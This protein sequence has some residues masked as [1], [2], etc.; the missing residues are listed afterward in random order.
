M[1]LAD[2]SLKSTVPLEERLVLLWEQTGDEGLHALCDGRAPIPHADGSCAMTAAERSDWISTCLMNC[3]KNTGNR[4]VFALLFEQNR[5]A[6]LHAIQAK[7]R[8]SS[9]HVDANDVL[10]EVF[11]NIYRYPHR[12][13][14]EHADSFRNW[15]HRIVRNTLLKFLKNEVRTLRTASLDEEETQ[16]ADAR[17]SSPLRSAS[18][19]ESAALVDWAYLVYLNLYLRHFLQLSEK[20]RRALTMV[21]VEGASYK[22]AATVLGIRLENL[23]M[24]IFRGRRK[25][26]RGMQHSLDVLATPL[27]APAP[28][29]SRPLHPAASVTTRLA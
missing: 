11:L 16:W 12:F 10:Q 29:T 7:L 23:K 4:E 13:L 17:A 14:A 9:G 27:P 22:T 21:E 28:A 20:E 6:F 15:G 1:E 19:S 8:H 3:Y 24:V 25:I 26:F 2:A 18:E 5:L